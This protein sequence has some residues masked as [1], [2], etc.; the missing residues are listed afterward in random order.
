MPLASA[1]APVS[2]AFTSVHLHE[3]GPK[4]GTRA[5]QAPSQPRAGLQCEEVVFNSPRSWSDL[6]N[7]LELF[8]PTSTSCF[9]L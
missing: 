5:S 3:S 7:A 8:L 9:R 1:S 4:H 2:N 6:E